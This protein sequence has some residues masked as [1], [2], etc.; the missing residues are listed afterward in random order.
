MKE[1]GQYIAENWRLSLHFWEKANL[2]GAAVAALV[3]VPITAWLTVEWTSLGQ[4]ILVMFPGI[5][6]LILA[7]VVTPF[8]MWRKQRRK[9]D[10]L[11]FAARSARRPKSISIMDFRRVAAEEFGWDFN[12]YSDQL[13]GLIG[14]LRQAAIDVSKT[15]IAIEGR[16]GCMQVRE[17][18]KLNFPLQ[19]IPSQYFID[20]SITLPIWSNWEVTTSKISALDEDRFRDLHVTDEERLREWLKTSANAFKS[21]QP[22][23]E[24]QDVLIHLAT[25]SKLNGM[26]EAVAEFEKHARRNVIQ[27]YGYH[28]WEPLGVSLSLS[29][30]PPHY[31]E[32]ARL[33]VQSFDIEERENVGGTDN[34]E[35]PLRRQRTISKDDDI[36]CRLRTNREKILELWPAIRSGSPLARMAHQPRL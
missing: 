7:L 19:L 29:K 25:H 9:L 21:A 10:E 2:F 12:D 36:F 31:W 18:T 26:P 30:L 22:N 13:V 8:D 28:L 6:L 24:V 4:K 32:Y 33:D 1:L 35:F 20:W 11:E 23:V 27:V 34:E 16:K 3:A 14:G 15:G 5:F 17:E